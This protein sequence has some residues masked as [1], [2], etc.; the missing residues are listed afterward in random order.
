MAWPR[1]AIA[2]SRSHK[3]ILIKLKGISKETIW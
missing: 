3:L 1:S 2:I